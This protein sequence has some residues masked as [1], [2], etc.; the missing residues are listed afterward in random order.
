MFAPG[1]RV[2]FPRKGVAVFAERGFMAGKLPVT[3][4]SKGWEGEAER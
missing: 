1:S 2:R 3:G 4:L